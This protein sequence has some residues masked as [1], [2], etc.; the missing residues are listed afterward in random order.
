MLNRLYNAALEHR[1][2]AW[3]Q[4][5]ASVTAYDQYRELTVLRSEDPDWRGL[6]VAVARGAIIRV[7][8]AFNAFFR[9]LRGGEKPGFPRFKPVS[10]F[11]TIEVRGVQEGMVKRNAEGTRAWLQIKGL[12]RLKFRTRR[13]L[14]EGTLKGIQIT[15]R[16]TGWYANLQYQVEREPMPE[17]GKAV[18]IDM[19]VRKRMALSS[20]E[21]VAPRRVD[22][23]RE[24]RLQRALSRKRKGSGG[25]RKVAASLARERFRNTVRNRNACHRLTTDLA[26]RF[27]FIA[28]EDLKVSNMTRSAKG[29]V[30]APGKNVK[31]KA[32]L[33]RSIIEQTWGMIRQ[34]LTYK[35]EWAGRRVELV[36]PKNTSRTCSRCGVIDQSSRE[37]ERHECRR[38]GMKMDADMNAAIN[39]LR[40]ANGAREY[41]AALL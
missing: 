27:G 29:T 11:R 41:R 25:R 31:A 16:P 18:G 6:S 12:P 17:V 20:G 36:N 4:A 38:C 21:T 35:A 15:R 13:P 14:P 19:G 24:A 10:R 30:D 37:G 8:R 1:R 5:G 34:Q 7:D 2:V 22:R 28:L 3:K 26:R 23:I 40:K 39:I 33:N 9:R 32:G